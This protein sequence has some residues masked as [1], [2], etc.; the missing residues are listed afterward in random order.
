MSE[1]HFVVNLEA[2][3]WRCDR[4]GSY[5]KPTGKIL[6]D[7]TDLKV[8]HMCMNTA[9]SSIIMLE[10]H[11]PKWEDLSLAISKARPL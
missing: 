6:K 9:C 8:E 4:C 10:T 1:E 3:D 5:C 7:F 2:I 11:Y